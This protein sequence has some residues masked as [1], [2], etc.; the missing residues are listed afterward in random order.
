MNIFNLFLCSIL[1]VS[2]L[3]SFYLS[4]FSR[5]F[6]V[7]HYM[8]MSLSLKDPSLHRLDTASLRQA[9]WCGCCFSFSCVS[10]I[11]FSYRLTYGFFYISFCSLIIWNRAHYNGRNPW[12]LI[13]H[14]SIHTELYF[15][16]H[17]YYIK[18]PNWMV[19]FLDNREIF[20]V[21]L[22]AISDDHSIFRNDFLF[23]SL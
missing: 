4:F 10:F 13:Q 9:I 19:V 18:S 22:V 23:L 11:L 15:Y 21:R 20:G 6:I 8:E 16:F 12:M 14:E 17:Y 5:I 2:L 7:F 3:E 1:L